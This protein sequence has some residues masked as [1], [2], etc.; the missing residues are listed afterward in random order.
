MF[1]PLLMLLLAQQS[2]P[3]SADT[4]YSSPTVKKVVS[5]RGVTS[6]RSPLVLAA[7][8]AKADRAKSAKTPV[9]IDQETLRTST[10]R[11]IMNN[12][13]ELPDAPPPID[14]PVMAS[15]TN[16][17]QPAIGRKAATRSQLEGKLSALRADAARVTEQVDSGTPQEGEEDELPQK[18]QKIQT[19]IDAVRKQLDA[20]PQ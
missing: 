20:M 4:A 8:K 10:G 9:K 5:S 19:E 14:A 11:L 2:P 6:P 1:A 18:Q 17:T 12:P 15:R 13:R 3:S 16:A 7:E